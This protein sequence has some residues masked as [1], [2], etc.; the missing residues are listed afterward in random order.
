MLVNKLKIK[1]ILPSSAEVKER[2]EA[3][4]NSP[5]KPSWYG[6]V[7]D[8]PLTVKKLILETV[9]GLK[10]DYRVVDQVLRL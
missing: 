8:L 5:S 6:L 9:K 7:R 1:K 10:T 2:V 4:L 3:Y